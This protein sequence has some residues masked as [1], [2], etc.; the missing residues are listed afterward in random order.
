MLA[1]KEDLEKYKDALLMK[2]YES[3]NVDKQ[4]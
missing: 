3:L 2:E 1:E 4:V